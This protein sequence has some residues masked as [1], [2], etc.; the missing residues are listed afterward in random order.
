M[1][2]FVFDSAAPNAFSD[3]LHLDLFGP[4]AKV[5]GDVEGFGDVYHVLWML[6]VKCQGFLIIMCIVI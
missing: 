1:R 4:V 2:A 5:A 6:V 3:L